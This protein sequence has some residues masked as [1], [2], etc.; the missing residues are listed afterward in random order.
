M[1]PEGDLNPYAPPQSEVAVPEKP[2]APPLP[3]PASTRWLLALMWSVFVGLACMSVSECLER[4]SAFFRLLHPLRAGLLS[5]W[6]LLCL[7]AFHSF[8]RSRITFALG[9][10]YLAFFGF[11]MWVTISRT[12]R[13]VMIIWAQK[14]DKTQSLADL[15]VSLVF[16]TLFVI[17]CHRFIFGLPSRRFYRLT[18]KQPPLIPPAHEL[19]RRGLSQI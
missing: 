8:K 9:V 5:F 3:R 15:F 10:S 7:A 11:I 6:L 2:D 4:G 18:Q 1:N 19:Q 17:L 12:V 16:T 13:R 14:A